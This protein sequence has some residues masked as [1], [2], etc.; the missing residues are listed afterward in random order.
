MNDGKTAVGNAVSDWNMQ[1]A[2]YV[3]KGLPQLAA[4]GQLPNQLSQLPVNA[5]AETAFLKLNF[6]RNHPTGNCPPNSNSYLEFNSVTM[7]QPIPL[8]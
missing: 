5:T 7:D 6:H 1:A 4:Q 3:P 8:N 2:A